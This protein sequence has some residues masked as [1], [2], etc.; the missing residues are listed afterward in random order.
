M[1][2]S[3]IFLLVMVMCLFVAS[4][5]LAIPSQEELVPENAQ[6]A[7]HIDMEKMMSTRL[8]QNLQDEDVHVWTWKR[9]HMHKTL[10][11]D[12]IKDLK[13]VTV[14]WGE[15]MGSEPVALIRG[16]FNRKHLLGLLEDEDSY[17]QTTYGKTTVHHWDDNDFGA[18]YGEDMI[19][20]SESEKSLIAALDAL[21][22]KSK[23]VPVSK[24]VPSRMMSK[25]VFITAFAADI[26][27][28]K[29]HDRSFILEKMESMNMTASERGDKLDIRLH[30]MTVAA[31]DA[32]NMKHVIRGLMAMA[33]LKLEEIESKTKIS[34]VVQ[35]STEGKELHLQLVYP[36]EELLDIILGKKNLDIFQLA[37]NLHVYN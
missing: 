12:P 32:E 27:S 19:V 33:D 14:F 20:Y 13:S 18:F 16:K 8:G 5:L 37:R 6:W 26:P 1:K 11:F 3:M 9:K 21:T 4:M 17:R 29:K 28:L 34:D 25:D 36:V 7:I 31:K 35:I 24:F 30:L 2:K 10:R 15:S 22:G 23:G